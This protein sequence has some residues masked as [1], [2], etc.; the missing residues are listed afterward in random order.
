MKHRM[1]EIA[2]RITAGL[3]IVPDDSPWLCPC[4][5]VVG[6][7]VACGAVVTAGWVVVAGGWVVGTENEIKIKGFE[8][9]FYQIEEQ[10]ITYPT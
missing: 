1:I 9:S 2:I 3:A 6:G 8:F 7:L 10:W 4:A 5:T